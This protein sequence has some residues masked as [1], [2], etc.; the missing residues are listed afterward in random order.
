MFPDWK[1]SDATAILHEA[2]G[3]FAYSRDAI[4]GLA[5]MVE[6][7]G[8]TILSGIEVTEFE[9]NSS[10]DTVR[11]IVTNCGTIDVDS[12]VVAVGPW[13]QRLWSMLQLPEKIDVRDRRG[14]LHPNQTMWTYWQLLEGEIH[15]GDSPYL[16]E[17]GAMPPTMHIDSEEPLSDEDGHAVTDG[18]WGI[19]YKCD[20]GNVQGG[21]VPYEIGAEAEV[22]PY[23]PASPHY[24]VKD[25]FVR[26]WTAGLAGAQAF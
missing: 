20:H 12:V 23:G 16:L 14:D 22:D 18:P 26:Y 25:E 3:G 5:R 21:A 8:V 17:N 6:R 1:E 15:M 24:T 2:K 13:V 9:L 11:S 10:D 4:E 7:Q 19:Y